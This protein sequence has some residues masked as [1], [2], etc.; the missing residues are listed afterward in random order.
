MSAVDSI[1]SELD[2]KGYALLPSVFTVQEMQ[3]LI[4]L[5]SV[6]QRELTEEGNAIRS[7]AGSV[8][9]GRNVIE[10][11]PESRS[12]WRRSPLTEGLS[13]VL[14]SAFGLVRVLFFD[15]PPERSW[16]LPWHKDLTIAVQSHRPVE[17]SFSKP[18]TK[19]GIP[20]VEAPTELLERMLTLRIHLDEVT[21]ENGP[22][23]VVPGSHCHGK[24]LALGPVPHESILAGCGDVLVIRPLVTHASGH[25]HPG[26]ARHRRILHLEFADHSAASGRLFLAYVHSGKSRR[27]MTVG[28]RWESVR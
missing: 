24:E 8:Y 1:K 19:A 20:H 23:K 18:T 16:T 27:G 25:S 22:L 4:G 14:G 17:G 6:R 11:L 21:E 10:W 28:S 7:R 5:L 2:A 9:A 12:I 26:T 13:E 15:K 3:D